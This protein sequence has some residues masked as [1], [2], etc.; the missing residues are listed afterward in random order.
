[1]NVLKSN[2]AGVSFERAFMARYLLH[3]IGDIHQP[4]HNTM[5][6][7]ETYKTG[8]LGGNLIHITTIS[9]ADINLHSYFDSIAEEQDTKIPIVRPLSPEDRKKIEDMS[10]LIMKRYPAS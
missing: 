6:F 3:L 9:G 2:K 10:E 8:D 5:M 7:N 1:M 4:L